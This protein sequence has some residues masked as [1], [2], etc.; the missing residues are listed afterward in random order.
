VTI[1]PSLEPPPSAFR[2]L[3]RLC[4]DL[5]VSGGPGAY[6][7]F[8]TLH[9]PEDLVRWLAMSPLTVVTD[10]ATPAELVEAKLLRWA[11]WRCA[12]AVV[13]HA[14]LDVHDLAT[15]NRVAAEPPLVPALT[16]VSS[17]GPPNLGTKPH[18]A[19]QEPRVSQAL[20][21][22]ARDAISLF[23]DPTQR[24]RLRRCAS[25]DCELIFYDGSR[26]GLRRWCS[27]ERCGDRMRARAYRARLR[28]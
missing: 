20:S 16:V 11:I 1:T 10:V 27:N 5:A 13:E 18:R 2:F 25:P 17:P 9:E 19:W 4:L 24:A 8:E 6:V 14:E 7:R 15:I 28:S 21:S 12:E 26:P 23:S 22:V 3:G